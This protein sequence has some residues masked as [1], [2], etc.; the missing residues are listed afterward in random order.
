MVHFSGLHYPC[1]ICLVLSKHFKLTWVIENIYHLDCTVSDDS[2]FSHFNCSHFLIYFTRGQ[3]SFHQ[4]GSSIE[5]KYS[6]NQIGATGKYFGKWCFI[7]YS[8]SFLHIWYLVSFQKSDPKTTSE[9]RRKWRSGPERE[10]ERR[11]PQD[12]HATQ[13]HDLCCW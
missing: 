7:I 5:C 13:N 3:H 9:G 6:W 4:W 10:R 11:P 2:F 12:R 1:K 8:N